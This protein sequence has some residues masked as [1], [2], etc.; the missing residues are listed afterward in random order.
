MSNILPSGFAG[1][2]GG[3]DPGLTRAL[4]DYSENGA[5]YGVLAALARSRVFIPIVAEAGDTEAG[6]EGLVHDRSADVSVVL[7]QRPDGRRALLAFTSVAAVSAW[8]AE[9][10]PRPLTAPDAAR[11]ALDEGAD[12]LL[13]D[14]DGPVRFAAEKADLEHLVAGHQIVATPSGYGWFALP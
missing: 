3:A 11:A 10:R 6:P 9:A 7:F 8:N 12:A 1:D 13:L 14:I 4:V 2:A 5:A